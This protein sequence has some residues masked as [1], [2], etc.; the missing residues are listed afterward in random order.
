MTRL[1]QDDIYQISKSLEQLDMELMAKTGLTLR[2]IACAAS[3]VDEGQTSGSI[4]GITAAVVPVT[5][6]LG[7]ISGF[8]DTV[9]AILKH[10]GFSS[11]TTDSTDAGGVSEAFLRRADLL[12]MADDHC[13]TALNLGNL[14]VVDNAEATARGFVAG[15]ERMSGG[16]DRKTVL[17]LGCGPVGSAAAIALIQRGA[18]VALFDLVRERAEAL[19]TE[20]PTGIATVVKTDLDTALMK[21]NHLI[22]ATPSGAFIKARHISVK[23]IAAGPGVPVGLDS[24][25]LSTMN[26]RFLHDPLETG[27]ATMAVL[28]AFGG[29]SCSGN[30]HRERT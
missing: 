11:F 17:V 24:D 7:I 2:G 18:R 9:S 10:I 27:V 1:K 28:A 29:I 6:G 5:A 3:G 13:F 30:A 15:L 20:L 16:F 12:L 19:A 8:S 21:Y 14:K 22:D 25:A 23:T 26:D 4:A